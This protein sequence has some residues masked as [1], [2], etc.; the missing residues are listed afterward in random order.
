[1]TENEPA[2]TPQTFDFATLATALALFRIDCRRYPTTDEGLRALLQPPAEADVRQRWQGPYIGHAGQLQ[3]PWGHDLQYICPGSHNP[4]SYD[5]SSAG[6]DGRH[7]S[8][9][10]VCNWRK[11]AP[12]AA[13][14]AAG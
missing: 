2:A 7:G 12:S 14:P 11:D 13:P 1:M 8:P 9:D 10:D 6:P 4:F 3:D 5:L